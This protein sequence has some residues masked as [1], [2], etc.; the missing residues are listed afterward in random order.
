MDF[1]QAMGLMRLGQYVRRA[2]WNACHLG[3][4]DWE[5]DGEEFEQFFYDDIDRPVDEWGM[6]E[7][8]RSYE[9]TD[10]DRAATDWVEHVLWN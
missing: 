7:D 10:E 4:V 6:N 1:E 2:G 9:L 3:L 8:I 5:A